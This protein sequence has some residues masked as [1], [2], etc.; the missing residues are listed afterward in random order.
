MIRSVTYHGDAMRSGAETGRALGGTWHRAYQV[1]LPAP[2]K[3]AGWPGPKPGWWV[4]GW[5]GQNWAPAAVRGAPLYLG[6]WTFTTGLYA[7]QTKDVIIVAAS[8]NT[9]YAYADGSASATQLWTRSLGTPMT[10]ATSNIDAPVGIASTPVLDPDNARMFV[11]ALVDG[12]AG[13]GHYEISCLD[14]DS[15]NVIQ[16]ATLADPGGPGRPTFNGDVQDQRGALNLVAGLVFATFAAYAAYDYG[17]YNGWLVGC[18]ANNLLRQT[19]LPLTRTVYGGGSWGPGGAAL[20]ADGALYVATGNPTAVIATGQSLDVANYWATNPDPGAIGDIADGV[21]K[22]QVSGSPGNATLTV[23]D[24]FFPADIQVEYDQDW[25]LGCSSV[26]PLPTIGGRNMAVICGKE[27]VVY[28]LDRDHMGHVGG[29]LSPIPPTSPFSNESKTAPA[30]LHTSTADFVYVS[31]SGAPG[32]IAFQVTGTTLTEV[33]RAQVG[34]SDLSLGDGPGS[35]VLGVNPANPDQALVWIADCDTQGTDGRLYAFNATSGALV[36]DSGT[37]GPNAPGE[38]AHFPGT[39]CVGNTVLLG[40]WYGFACYRNAIHKVPKELKPEKWEHKDKLEKWEG[41]FEKPESK[42][43][44]FEGG[45]K[46]QF[47]VPK[48]KDNEGYGP[49][50]QIGDPWQLLQAL[51]ARVDDIETRLA[52]GRAFIRPEERPDVGEPPSLEGDSEDF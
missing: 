52:E 3:P 41:K 7:G 27:G 24:W 28:L 13:T 49:N 29:Q 22:V 47:D 37:S 50:E 42:V 31:A 9:V 1:S 44:I 36:F 8:D 48:I 20:G 18:D 14:L 32:L 4:W 10:R 43:E 17:D 2:A 26:L 15:G 45:V 40:T 39:T 33:W 51:A 38:L 19:F 46:Q 34:G 6:G 11:M 23:V 12:G 30:Y 5:G 21:A 16:T 25:D 35:P